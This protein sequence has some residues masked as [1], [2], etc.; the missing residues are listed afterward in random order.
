[1]KILCISDDR[2]PLVYSDNVKK[3]FGDIDLVLSAGDLD[4]DYYGFLVSSLNKPLLFVFGNHNLQEI[5]DYRKEYADAYDDDQGIHPHEP[6]SYGATYVG[7][8]VRRVGG[9]IIAGLGGS[10]K[11]NDGQN[12]FTEAGMF[13]YALRLL[14][15]LIFNRI[16]HGRFVDILLT[17]AAPRGIH[18][19]DDLPHRG[20]KVFVWFMRYFKPKLLVHGHVHLY[21]INAKRFARY[22]QTTVVNAY[23][24]VVIDTEDFDERAE[25]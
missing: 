25:H 12:Q 3:R 23:E 6:R 20:F 7:G 14:P 22:G 15:A 9:L 18:D 2:D 5:S 10:M 11:Y 17:H 16:F 24:H 21:D 1:M 8:R 4:L 13:W 19:G